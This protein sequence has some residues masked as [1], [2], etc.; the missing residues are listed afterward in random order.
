M[1]DTPP[2]ASPLALLAAGFGLVAGVAAI[3]F[4]VQAEAPETW[5][6][7]VACLLQVPPSLHLWQRIREGFGNR[8]LDRERRILRATSHLLRLLALG[9]AIASVLA[10]TEGTSV[11]TSPMGFGLTAGAT[12]G[13][14]ALWF[15]KRRLVGR[16]PS[17]D[18]DVARLRTMV[19]LAVL[20]LAGGLLGQVV[21]WAG[22]AA[23]LVLAV[24]LFVEGRVL[25]RGTTV[26]LV[27][28]GG[29]GSCGCG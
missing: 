9:L 12:L 3:T 11:R 15:T 22:A 24:R 19:E 8:G 6:L 28:C 27:G 21:P 16:H 10:W 7:G 14:L 2:L 1:M 23:G 18:L 25:A 13:F 26:S 17:L 20:A 29:C 5:G 4:G